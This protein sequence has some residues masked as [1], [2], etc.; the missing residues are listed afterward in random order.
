M[1]SDEDIETAPAKTTPT[2][3]QYM[4]SSPHA[5]EMFPHELTKRHTADA[6]RTPTGEKKA[7]IPKWALIVGSTV[8]LLIIAA[9]GY[10]F[11]IMN[12][13]LTPSPTTPIPTVA[14]EAKVEQPKNSYKLNL[15]FKLFVP[16]NGRWERPLLFAAKDGSEGMF[17][18]S[19]NVK[20]GEG[21]AK[22]SFAY[23]IYPKAGSSYNPP[24]D[25]GVP[26]HRTS[27]IPVP[28]TRHKGSYGIVAYTTNKQATPGGITNT[29]ITSYISM[30]AEKEGSVIVIES[31]DIK[32]DELYALLQT[33]QELSPDQIPQDSIQLY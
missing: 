30:F 14:P 1:I 32:A 16:P 8:V 11:Y 25:C 9:V 15:S 3:E 26:G 2:R 4:S 18:Y 17:T 23:S 10:F 33:M 20:F 22:G 13:V 31:A 5:P 24:S 21:L 12:T 7:K 29:S 27:D 6:P 28:C 19:T